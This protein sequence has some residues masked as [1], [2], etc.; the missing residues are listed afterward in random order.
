MWYQLHT[1]VRRASLP[2]QRQ[3]LKTLNYSAIQ[4]CSD[5]W[6]HFHVWLDSVSRPALP[7]SCTTTSSTKTGTLEISFRTLLST[8]ADEA[9]CVIRILKAWRSFDTGPSSLAL[10]MSPSY[11]IGPDEV[12]SCN[13]ISSEWDAIYRF[14]TNFAVL[15]AAVIRRPL[16]SIR[17]GFPTAV[18]LSSHSRRDVII[19]ENCSTGK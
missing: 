1:F 13:L 9:D 19:I 16:R 7:K 10:E 17:L 4:Y 8:L 6:Y 3:Q 5:H 11:A 14:S 12:T 2:L 18:A 15:G